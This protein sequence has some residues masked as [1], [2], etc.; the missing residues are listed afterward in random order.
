MFALPSEDEW[1]KAARGPDGRFYPWG[2][3]ADPAFC[4]MTDSR[5]REPQGKTMLPEPLGLFPIDESPF[6]VRDLGGGMREWTSTEA[7]AEKQWRIIKGGAW[8][9]PV[10]FCRSADRDAFEPVY[11][12]TVDGLRLVARRTP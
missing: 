5:S 4:R 3:S 6:G 10:A 2:D 12:N 7:G 1:E 8:S 9:G 11:V